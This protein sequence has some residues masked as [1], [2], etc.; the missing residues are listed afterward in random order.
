MK[1]VMNYLL[2]LVAIV[3][4]SGTVIADPKNGTI[5]PA[6]EPTTLAIVGAVLV[7]GLAA[8]RLFGRK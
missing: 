6:P 1:K 2:A 8:R 4:L 7:G 3:N 5:I